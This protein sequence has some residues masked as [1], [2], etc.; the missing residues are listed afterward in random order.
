MRGVTM[1]ATTRQLSTAAVNALRLA[2]QQRL[3]AVTV[4]LSRLPEPSD[5]SESAAI[6]LLHHNSE[7]EAQHVQNA[8]RS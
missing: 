6:A 8:R 5:S 3:E 1:Q 4:L 7:A 2:I